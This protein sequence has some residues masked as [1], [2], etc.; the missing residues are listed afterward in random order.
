MCSSDLFLLAF[1]AFAADPA[2][3]LLAAAKKGKNAQVRA[4][5][6]R[7][8][9]LEA[10][11]RD[12]RT[13]LM[14]AAQYGRVETVR[15]LLAKG[16]QPGARDRRG[17]NAYMLALISPAGGVVHTIHDQVLKLLP[18]PARVRLAVDANWSQ[19]RE[20]FSS[21]FLRPPELVQHIDAL[22]P[23][24][25]VREAF[26]NFAA[27]SGRG[28]LELVRAPAEADASLSLQVEPGA[29]CVRSGDRLSLLIHARLLRAPGPSPV[30]EKTFG[31]GVKT[32]IRGELASN[33]AQYA[34]IY[35]AWAKSQAG[36]LYWDVLAALM[37]ATQ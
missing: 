24:A 28:L 11:D 1:S 20:L 5:L 37:Q 31:P 6:D 12:G 30:L 16:A 23:D 33:A 7:G 14:L 19:G 15:L 9:N 25:L 8:A 18:Q 35:E 26:Q 22:R 36:P 29:T 2:E 34:P 32:G 17:W 10:K 3:D 13:P 4:L 21:C 27:T